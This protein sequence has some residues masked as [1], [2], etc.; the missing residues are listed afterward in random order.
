MFVSAPLQASDGFLFVTQAQFHQC[1]VEG[2]RH[3]SGANE[4]PARVEENP[5]SHSCEDERAVPYDD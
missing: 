2:K 4:V 5:T 3:L 1:Q